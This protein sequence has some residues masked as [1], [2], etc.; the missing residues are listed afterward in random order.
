[1]QTIAPTRVKLWI[2]AA[3]VALAWSSPAV[4]A[5]ITIIASDVGANSAGGVFGGTDTGFSTAYGTR[6]LSAAGGGSSSEM[7]IDWTDTGSGARFDYDF[8]HRR[9]GNSGSYGQTYEAGLFFTVGA[10]DTT[11]SLSGLYTAIGPANQTYFSVFLR[12]ET[13]GVMLF[14]DFSNSFITANEVFALGVAGDAD[15]GNS[16]TGSLTGTLVAGRRY[17]FLLDSY[18]YSQAADL[19]G[20]A[21]GCVTL[22]IGGAAADAECGVAAERAA[23]VVPE[24]G[25]LALA[26]LA[27]AGLGL[28]RR[29]R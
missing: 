17:K 14:A 2:G 27:L 21:T 10:S 7:L 15:L 28:A 29:R 26:G 24:P 13:T 16:T 4:A 1:M 3:L 8:D 19:G 6:S 18:I 12:D 20:T 22:S 25:S 5:P 9:V 23:Q 11:Y